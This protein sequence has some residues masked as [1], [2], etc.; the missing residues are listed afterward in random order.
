MN[1]HLIIGTL[2]VLTIW[3]L[4]AIVTEAEDDQDRAADRLDLADPRVASWTE[5]WSDAA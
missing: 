4:S 3:W 2:L 5:H 1:W